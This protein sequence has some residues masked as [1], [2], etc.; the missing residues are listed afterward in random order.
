ME[1]RDRDGDLFTHI[2]VVNDVYP[3]RLTVIP[4]NAALAAWTIKG[5]EEVPTHEE[6]VE[7]LEKVAMV[8][9]AK[10]ADG[11]RATL[12]TWHQRLGHPSF[13]TVIALA[14]NGV[15]GMEITDLLKTVPG[16]DACTACVATWR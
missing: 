11:T 13:K 10:G 8:A 5:D 14:K 9:T 16:L 12:M 2:A 6:L 7:R 3:V 1:L 15:K 4:P